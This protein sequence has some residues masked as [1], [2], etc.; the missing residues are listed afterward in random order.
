MCVFVWPGRAE[1]TRRFEV[2]AEI[3]GS[4]EPPRAIQIEG[5]PQVVADKDGFDRYVIRIVVPETP[6]G[7]YALR[8]TFRDP[9]NG[10]V[11]QSRTSVFVER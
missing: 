5:A 11:T 2:G 3:T 7:S 4:G 8:L 10:V 6:P 9:V 1:P